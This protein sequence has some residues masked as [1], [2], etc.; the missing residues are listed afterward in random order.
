[1]FFFFLPFSPPESSFDLVLVHASIRSH[2]PR[3]ASP[4]ILLPA[5]ADGV[6]LQPLPHLRGQGG[7]RRVVDRQGGGRETQLEMHWA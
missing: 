6:C 7:A 4:A 2:G 5:V 3:L 1:M